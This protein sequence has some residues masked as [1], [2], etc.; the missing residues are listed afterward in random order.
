M[1]TGWIAPQRCWASAWPMQG[2]GACLLPRSTRI[3]PEV[4]VSGVDETAGDGLATAAVVGVLAERKAAAVAGRRPDA[5]VLAA[6]ET[7]SVE[8]PA[9][10]AV[11]LGGAHTHDGVEGE[12]VQALR[13]L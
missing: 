7:A 4:L 13:K 12:P 2:G 10:R 8:A 3:D 6:A 5:L 9:C 11:R 1:S